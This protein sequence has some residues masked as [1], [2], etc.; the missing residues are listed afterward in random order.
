MDE[1]KLQSEII[2]L[3]EE[4]NLLVFHSAD[5]RRDIGRGFPDLV[6]V[7][8]HRTL[9]AELKSATGTRTTD[10]TNWYYRLSAVGDHV[11]LW[12]PKDWENGQV[13]TLLREL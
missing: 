11:T 13:E 12:R 10:Q 1:A 6:I 9:F 5:S 4:L 8:R 2:A 3:A 7:G